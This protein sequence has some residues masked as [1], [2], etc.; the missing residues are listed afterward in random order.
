MTMFAGTVD[1]TCATF[2]ID[3]S[4]TPAGGDPVSGRVIARRP[5]MIVDF[6]GSRIHAETATFQLRASE[7]VSLRPDD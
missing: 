5:D 2:G 7:V 6:G 3:A 4:Y 1:A